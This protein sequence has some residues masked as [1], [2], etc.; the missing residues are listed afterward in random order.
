MLS[1][2]GAETGAA[3]GLPV[4]TE[5]HERVLEWFPNAKPFVLPQAAHLL[6]VENPH[7]MA[8]ALAAFLPRN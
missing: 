3:I 8:E 1:V 6:Q 4:Y 2:V 7:D 5:I